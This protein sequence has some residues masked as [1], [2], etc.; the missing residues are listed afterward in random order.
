M[1][2]LFLA[3]ILGCGTTPPDGHGHGDDHAHDAGGP[4][5]AV[6]RW[7]DTH[8]LFVE[9]DAPV[10]GAPFAYHAH[11]TRLADNHAATAGTL[12]L[13]LE[14][15]G[16]AV[17][18]H[19][20]PEIARAGIFAAEATAPSQAGTYQLI[21]TY[22]GDDEQLRWDAGPVILGTG[23]PVAQPSESEGEIAFL[24]E[25]QWQS[26]FRVAPARERDLAPVITAAGVVHSAPGS[27]ALV[28]APVDGLMVWTDALPV[29]GRS[30][31]RGEPLASLIPAGAAE[32]YASNRADLA[33]ARI[34][35]ALAEEDL[36]RVTSLADGEL[37]SARRLAEARAAVPRAQA[38]V[39][40]AGQRAAA[41]TSDSGAVVVRSPATGVIVEVG[42]HHGER[43]AAGSPLVRVHSG[44]E[45]LIEAR[46]HTR[47][48][49]SL[50]PVASLSVLRGDWPAPV[51]LVAAGS[52]VLTEHLIYDPH[53][54][55]APLDV[56]VTGNAGLGVGDLV[57]LEL[58][59]GEPAP[60]LAVGREAVVDIHGQSVV[61]VQTTG[62]SF[63]R[64]RVELGRRDATWVEVV[65]G[66][67]P[68]E[69]VVE[70]G[71]FL[72]HVISV[73]GALQ[74]H[75]H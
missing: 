36:A 24:K 17:S 19:T 25:D 5:I 72:V 52:R 4:S 7:T 42:G 23:A 15:E 54:L 14:R 32:H 20:D 35:L 45:L 62:E 26:R 66:V 64:R 31:T 61:F 16:L 3:L 13:Q 18:E 51:D 67:S 34:D 50:R 39:R 22:V 29:V 2:T 8:E 1:T 30:V 73:S 74:S 40:S 75:R 48:G 12:T 65:R 70:E 6:T 47:A 68:G 9:L 58:G 46:V 55:S 60:L 59:I 44:T 63:T 33:A 49:S 53:S 37:V 10:A 38:R 56:L 57:E 71:G 21:V 11:V 69:M 27:T 43:V 28:A 41:L